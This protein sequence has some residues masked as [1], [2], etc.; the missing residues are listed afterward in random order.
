MRN[1]DLSTKQKLL[2]TAKRLFAEY[3]YDY[4]STRMLAQEAGVGQSAIFFH[5]GSKEKLGAAVA[6]DIIY[7][8]DRY[9]SD[10]YQRVTEAY[11]TGT[12]TS[13][14]ALAFLLEYV[15]I[16]LE[17][18]S[19]PSNRLALRYFVNTHTLPP[20][21]SKPVFEVSKNQVEIP[22]AKL[23]CTYKGSDNISDAFI[24][25]HSIISSIVGYRMTYTP[26]LY[27]EQ[28]RFDALDQKK[29]FRLRL[30]R[31]LLEGVVL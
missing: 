23:L 3:N 7:Y 12:M 31:E 18:A 6:D 21:I 24:I 16:Q 13:E 1:N 20:D 28:F 4:V 26:K 10:L 25:T 5:F 19:L 17:I 11:E 29:E 9:Y 22:M 8:H 14:A 2:R 27:D 15:T 30:Y